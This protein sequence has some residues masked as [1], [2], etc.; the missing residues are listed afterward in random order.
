MLIITSIWEIIYSKFN[1]KYVRN[2][3]LH[4]CCFNISEFYKIADNCWLFDGLIDYK[5]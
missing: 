3:N 2:S 5:R 4:M 1:S